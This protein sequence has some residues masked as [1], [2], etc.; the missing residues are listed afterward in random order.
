MGTGSIFSAPGLAITRYF[1]RSYLINLNILTAYSDTA[2][3]WLLWLVA[4]G[5]A[6]VCSHV[7]LYP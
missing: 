3:I 2:Y 6:P 1:W 7:V 5:G 4:L